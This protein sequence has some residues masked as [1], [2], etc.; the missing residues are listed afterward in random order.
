MFG[1]SYFPSETE[2]SAIVELE[3]EQRASSMHDREELA[4]VARTHAVKV[5]MASVGRPDFESF[6]FHSNL[7]SSLTE[8]RR[9]RIQT[10]SH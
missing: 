10:A 2:D 7:P 5:S 8:A 4:K 9:R 1:D 6:F 3:L